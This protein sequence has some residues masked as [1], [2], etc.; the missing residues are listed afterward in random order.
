MSEETQTKTVPVV[1]DIPAEKR[2]QAK[3]LLSILSDGLIDIQERCLLPWIELV[4]GKDPIPE[5]VLVLSEQLI[6]SGLP[7]VQQ[8]TSLL[9]V[10]EESDGTSAGFAQLL[11]RKQLDAVKQAKQAIVRPDGTAARAGE[12]NLIVPGRK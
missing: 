10:A 2:E 11:R 1:S 9:S 5:L 4:G 6:R 8:M 3:N 12:S 7:F